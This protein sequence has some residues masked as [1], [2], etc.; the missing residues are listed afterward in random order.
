MTYCRV[1]RASA[2]RLCSILLLTFLG[3]CATGNEVKVDS[4]NKEYNPKLTSLKVE[5]QDVQCGITHT[6]MA[7]FIFSFDRPLY[8]ALDITSASDEGHAPSQVTK[9]LLV[10]LGSLEQLT[11][12]IQTK[13]PFATL[14]CNANPLQQNT[15]EQNTSILDRPKYAYMAL[16]ARNMPLKGMCRCIK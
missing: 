15:I 7:A 12:K 5:L 6:T 4:A 3:Y 10:P 16:A 9:D 8:V 2:V 13:D 1:L 14:T 11:A